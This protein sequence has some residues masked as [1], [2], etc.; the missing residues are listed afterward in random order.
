MGEGTWGVGRAAGAE[1]ECLLGIRYLGRV[2]TYRVRATE[3]D[4]DG[5]AES[6]RERGVLGKVGWSAAGVRGDCCIRAKAAQS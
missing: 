4:R 1:E 3:R 6:E 2:C 5:E